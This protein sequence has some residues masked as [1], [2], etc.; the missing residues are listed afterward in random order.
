ML[1]LLDRFFKIFNKMKQIVFKKRLGT[2]LSFLSCLTRD[3]LYHPSF[4][5]TI[6]L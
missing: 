2:E 6:T 5:G 1:N 3:N 4:V